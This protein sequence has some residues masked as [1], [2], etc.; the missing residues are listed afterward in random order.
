MTNKDECFKRL[1]E[2][3]KK[4]RTELKIPC[5]RTSLII[6]V[7]YGMSDRE[8]ADLYVA[9]KTTAQDKIDDIFPVE[10]EEEE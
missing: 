10:E 5:N 8:M 4:I 9:Y 3:A 1:D 7:L 6:G 2:I